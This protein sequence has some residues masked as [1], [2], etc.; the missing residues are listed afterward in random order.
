MGCHQ[1]HTALPQ[2]HEVPGW[3][4]CHAVLHVLVD[5]CLAVQ[6]LDDFGVYE[7]LIPKVLLFQ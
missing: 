6:R 1:Q 2:H 4:R 3:L 7:I 5:V